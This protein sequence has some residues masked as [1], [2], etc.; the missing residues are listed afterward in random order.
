MSTERCA[1]PDPAQSL[2]CLEREESKLWRLVLWLLALV[3]V[4]ARSDPP[5]VET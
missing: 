4:G 5:V 2:E 3:A 1:E